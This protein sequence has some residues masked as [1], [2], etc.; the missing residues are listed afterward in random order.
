LPPVSPEGDLLSLIL[1]LNSKKS[2]G[3]AIER[4]SY[5]TV[6]TTCFFSPKGRTQDC[7]GGEPAVFAVVRAFVIDG[8]HSPPEMQYS[9]LGYEMLFGVRYGLSRKLYLFGE[10]KYTNGDAKATTIDGGRVDAPL[11]SWHT[12][13]G[14]MW[15]L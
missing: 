14:I 7:L 9:S 13:L 11:R 15:E 12:A 1:L 3:N 2:Y 8:V 5:N 10:A 4:I 6:Q